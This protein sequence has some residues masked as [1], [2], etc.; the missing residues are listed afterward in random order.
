[1]LKKLLYR[2]GIAALFVTGVFSC[3]HKWDDHNEVDQGL[4]SETLFAQIQANTSLSVFAGYLKQTGYADTLIQSKSFTVWVPTN[5]ALKTLDPSLVS[6]ATWLKSF[7]AHHIALKSYYTTTVQAAGLRLPL[8]D[9]K[10]AFFAPDKF[11]DAALGS[12]NNMLASNG[13][14]HT[15]SSAAAPIVNSWDIVDSLKAT[16]TMAYYMKNLINRI[17][18]PTVATQTGVDPYSGKPIYDTPSGMVNVN[19]FSRQVYDLAK[20]DKQYTVFVLG[21]TAFNA[22]R[23]KLSPYFKASTADSVLTQTSWNTTKNLVVEGAYAEDQLPDTLI[24]KFGVKFPVNKASISKR[25]KTSNGYVYILEDMNIRLQH[26]ILPIVFEGE[27]ATSFSADRP[28]ALKY[29]IRTNPLTGKQ[30]TDLFVYDHQVTLFNV[31][32]RVNNVYSCKYKVYWV[33]ANDMITANFNQRL[34]VGSTTAATFPYVTVLP[35][36]FSEVYL[37]EFTVSNYTNGVQDFYLI[38]N[39]TTATSTNKDVIPLL[40]DYVRLEPV[41]E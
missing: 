24:S 25:Y 5:D 7:V 18:D 29:R 31:R 27:N 14:L 16:N 6:N 3:T 19:A 11:D 40:L 13:V 37:G 8:L 12:S 36:V 35:N 30:F 22:M 39:T 26:I 23:N 20:E 28:A 33:A 10:Y 4:G 34:T 1:M 41:I 9:G 21:N 32:Y 17:F 2:T 15:L 38:C